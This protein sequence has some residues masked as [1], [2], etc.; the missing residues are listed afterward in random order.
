MNKSSFIWIVVTS[1]LVLLT[2]FVLAQ[3]SLQDK[4]KQIELIRQYTINRESILAIKTAKEYL[5]TDPNNTKVL[6]ILAEN[7]LNV[8]AYIY[9]EKSV[10]RALTID[11]NN[12]RGRCV[13]AN[14]YRMKGEASYVDK[15]R[16]IYFDLAQKL[17]EIALIIDPSDAYANSDAAEIYFVRGN[18]D[19]A[20]QAIENALKLRPENEYFKRIKDKIQSMP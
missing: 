15:L 9:A 18:K 8:G 10:K 20:I 4:A 11:P 7:C 19:K 12:L 5:K 17:I 13:L 3:P 1:L 16:K 14:A 2:S 6:I